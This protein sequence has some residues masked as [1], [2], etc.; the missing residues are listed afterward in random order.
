MDVLTL[1]THHLIK[2]EDLNHHGTLYAGRGAEWFVESGFT[3]AASITQPENIVCSKIHGMAFT[4][5]VKKGEIIR[6]DSK[7]ILSGHTRLVSFVRATV[8]G[9][10][11][12]EGFIT[13]V[14]VD[15]EGSP[16]PHGV[17]ITPTLPEDIEL[18]KKAKTL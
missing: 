13:F 16:I 2:G 17:E 10:L 8:K 4:R 3:A 11:A 12:L 18:H 1:T 6:Y 7:V 15:L 5:P 14:H 9:E